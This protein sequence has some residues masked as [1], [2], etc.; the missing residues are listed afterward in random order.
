MGADEEIGK[1]RALCSASPSIGQE[2]L[3]CEKGG[4]VRNRFTVEHGSWKRDVEFFDLRVL[5]R[6]RGINDGIDDKAIAVGGAFDGSRRPRK[7]TRVLRHD[8]EK[9]V[10]VNQYGRHLVI[11]G[12]RHD[13]VRTHRDISSAPQMGDKAGTATVPLAGRRANYAHDFAIKFEVHFGMVAASHRRDACSGASDPRNGRHPASSLT[14]KAL[15]RAGAVFNRQ[16]KYNRG[17]RTHERIPVL[18]VPGDRPAAQRGGGLSHGRG[19]RP[20]ALRTRM[21]GEISKAIQPN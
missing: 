20:P 13:G 16:Y 3:A 21:N 17:G 6:D 8:V 14:P 1:W 7:P 10:G 19:S 12:E 15:P 9:D 11:A 18:R 5:N 2:R 4:F